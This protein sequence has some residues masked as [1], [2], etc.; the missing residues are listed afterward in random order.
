[1]ATSPVFLNYSN[2]PQIEKSSST[3]VYL[4]I[5]NEKCKVI[6]DYGA[7][8]T[9]IDKSVGKKLKLKV[10]EDDTLDQLEYLTAN[11]EPLKKLG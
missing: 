6:V 8:S 1:V 7:A 10:F 4:K 11:G 5:N 9:L 2:S 3:Y